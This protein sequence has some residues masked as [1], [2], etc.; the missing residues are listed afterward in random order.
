MILSSNATRDAPRGAVRASVRRCAA[1]SSALLLFLLV[2]ALP[3]VAHAKPLVEK[4]SNGDGTSNWVV[5][6]TPTS[7]EGNV[8]K[9][10][11][12]AAC[13]ACGINPKRVTSGQRAKL[14]NEGTGGR[15]YTFANMFVGKKPS[16][17]SVGVVPGLPYAVSFW[18][19]SYWA[20]DNV[21][22]SLYSGAIYDLSV[23]MRG[24]DLGDGS[25]S[26]SY[27]IVAS[28]NARFSNTASSNSVTNIPSSTGYF[29]DG[30]SRSVKYWNRFRPDGTVGNW[31]PVNRS[32]SQTRIY[33]DINGFLKQM[34]EN[35]PLSEY[36]YFLHMNGLSSGKIE[37]TNI[38]IFPKGGYTMDTQNG[39]KYWDGTQFV[40]VPYINRVTATGEWHFLRIYFE[41]TSAKTTYDYTFDGSSMTMEAKDVDR[42]ELVHSGGNNYLYS[43]VDASFVLPVVSFGDE[44]GSPNPDSNWPDDDEGDDDDPVPTPP[45]VPGPPDIPGDPIEPLP[46][47]PTPPTV[48]PDPTGTDVIPYLLVII[49]RLNDILA[50]V[51]YA[52]INLQAA[53]IDHCLHIRNCITDRISWLA[54]Y[55]QTL[56][57]W[58]A[59]Q[60]TFDVSGGGYDDST[61]VSWLKQIY[62]KLTSTNI[63]IPS[64]RP[65]DNDINSN[66]DWWG[67]LLN[68]IAELLG[69]GAAE[70]IDAIVGL[71]EGVADKF[72][73]SVPWDFVAVFGLLVATPEVP[74]FAFTIPA[75]EGWWAAT[76]IEIDLTPYDTAMAAVRHMVMI[77]WVMTLIRKTDWMCGIF[78]T[79]AR[80]VTDL[81]HGARP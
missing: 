49:H 21:P 26:D 9:S 14:S 54:G 45:P 46:P 35:Y 77:A 63:R 25:E 61:V 59:E 37:Y 36:D 30:E 50:N 19:L 73:F 43:N 47:D 53:M 24:E 11:Y 70:A 76:Q 75:I 78:A 57:E 72:P 28:G 1:L 39:S 13:W 33:P 18:G 69:D 32:V 80:V 40:T 65:D 48:D 12:S 52:V 15:F 5:S 62:Y 66:F 6:S 51:Y 67:W 60:L 38:Y 64:T 16:N 34:L 22:D 4:T 41:D 68:R 81:M 56:C 71:L 7:D 27:R 3:C 2:L 10:K 74:R 79:G 58:L 23:V 29:Y 55:M 20:A 44:A 31:Q 8:V 42:Y 17:P